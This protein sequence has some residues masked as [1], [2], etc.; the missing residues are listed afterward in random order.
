MGTQTR[1]E[2]QTA[3]IEESMSGLRRKDT[4]APKVVEDKKMI[5]QSN[6]GDIS[7]SIDE[8]AENMEDRTVKEQ[9]EAEDKI[10]VVETN[11]ER[12]PR[13]SSFRSKERSEITRGASIHF[14][15]APSGVVMIEPDTATDS[16]E[17]SDKSDKEGDRTSSESASGDELSEAEMRKLSLGVGMKVRRN[18]LDRIPTR[19]ISRDSLMVPH[20]GV[21]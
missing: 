6:R 17:D 16:T 3:N 7:F 21:G 11:F 8:V 9:E 2:T 14:D 18:S 20:N 13:R 12:Q 10:R 1:E 4:P 15:D 5:F 19:K